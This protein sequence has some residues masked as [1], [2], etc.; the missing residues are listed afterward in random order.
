MN[1]GDTLSLGIPTYKAI[2]H[3][4]KFDF[5]SCRRP[6]CSP[7]AHAL[8]LLWLASCRLQQL[9]LGVVSTITIRR[10]QQSS[11]VFMG[12]RY[13]VTMPTRATATT[14]SIDVLSYR[15]EDR[16][17]ESLNYPP[18]T[19]GHQIQWSQRTSQHTIFTAAVGTHMPSDPIQIISYYISP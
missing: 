1:C 6:K 13:P 18:R 8:P 9:A 2:R 3:D 7:T 17:Q 4:D 14:R 10:H 11:L 15:V 5:L 16:S 12:H 19:V